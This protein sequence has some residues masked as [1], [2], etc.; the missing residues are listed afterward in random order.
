MQDF[1]HRHSLKKEEDRIII[2]ALEKRF[3]SRK[4]NSLAELN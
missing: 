4:L 1:L 2:L 3:L